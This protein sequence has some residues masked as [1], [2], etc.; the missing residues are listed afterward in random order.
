MHPRLFML[1][2]ILI[3]LVA[4]IFLLAAFVL[5]RMLLF[6]RHSGITYL[7]HESHL[8]GL[9]VD[10]MAVAKNL[11]SVIQ[12]ETISHEDTAEDNKANFKVMQSQLAKQYPL[13]H[14]QL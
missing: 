4:F 10:E 5:V 7:P 12:T 13:T 1:S 2:T 6:T 9:V 11:S 3:F 14:S 8:P